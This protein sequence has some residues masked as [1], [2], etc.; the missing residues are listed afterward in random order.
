MTTS[1]FDR[2]L[3]KARTKR[4][5]A[6]LGL[7]LAA[8]ASLLAG[9]RPSDEPGVHV[10]GWAMLDPAQRHP[11]VVGQQPANMSV[12]IARGSQGLN[13]QQRASI[14]HF[15]GRYRGGN[16]GNGRLTIS[17]PSGTANEVSAL[18]AVAD[19]RYLLRDVGIDDSRVAVQPYRGDGDAQAPIRISYSSFVA[20]GPECGHWGRNLADDARNL[21][22][23]NLGCA[24]QRNFAAQVANP[25]D[26]LGP[27]TMTPAIA[28]RR[29][30][31][32]EKFVKGESTIA[33]KDG[34]EKVQ[35]QG[36]K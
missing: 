29:D 36:S 24:T 11:I 4:Q 7:G 28:E 6:A 25:A 16:N 17:V 21:P 30:T 14:V 33:K 12:R 18:H 31:T 8:F 34:E 3:E 13:P 19:L 10:A 1:K 15:L 35:V 20:E 32:W 27:R 26:L 5:A 22:H 2:A 23:A 9:C